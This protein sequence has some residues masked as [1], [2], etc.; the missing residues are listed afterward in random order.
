MSCR[1]FGTRAA[2]V[3]DC[4]RADLGRA[5]NRHGIKGDPENLIRW[6]GR[7]RVSIHFHNCAGNYALDLP[8]RKGGNSL[9]FLPA[10]VLVLVLV[11]VIVII[12]D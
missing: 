10:L 9:P 5:E 7:D 3:M 12:I 11:L 6:R 4:D 8:G 2:N 1:I